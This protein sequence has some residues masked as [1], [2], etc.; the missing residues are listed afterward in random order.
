MLEKWFFFK[1][2][3]TGRR[4]R[5]RDLGKGG[6]G[7]SRNKELAKGK[8]MDRDEGR[9]PKVLQGTVATTKMKKIIRF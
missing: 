5:G 6:P 8:A 9:R 1:G 2:S 7:D 4:R 3:L